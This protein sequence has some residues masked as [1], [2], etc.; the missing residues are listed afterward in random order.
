M[1]PALLALAL[2][3]GAAPGAAQTL[4]YVEPGVPGCLAA[5][6]TAAPAAAAAAPRQVQAGTAVSG[7]LRVRCGLDQGSYTVTL[8]SPDPRATF[9][10]KTMLVNFGRV[11]GD[12]RFVVTFATP[13][14]QTITPTITANMGSPPARGQFVG[15]DSLFE[16]VAR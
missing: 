16:V 1:V 10:P 13:G 5:P 2:I 8:G 7:R 14:V 3:L 6:S 9:V 4:Q 15:E 12:G 11:V